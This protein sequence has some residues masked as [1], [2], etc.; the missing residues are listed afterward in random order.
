MPC[1]TACGPTAPP[2]LT[3]FAL[4]RALVVGGLSS[5]LLIAF[6]LFLLDLSRR[7]STEAAET[8]RSLLTETERRLDAQRR[9]NDAAAMDSA[10]GL[11]RFSAQA[12]ISSMGWGMEGWVGPVFDR[13][14]WEEKVIGPGPVEDRTCWQPTWASSSGR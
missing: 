2:S 3:S 9:L 1:A 6:V 12:T 13:P 5:G 7:R 10:T 11:P 4:P 8:A 14:D